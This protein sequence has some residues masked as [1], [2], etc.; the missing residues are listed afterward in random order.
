[1]VFAFVSSW[2]TDKQTHQ[3]GANKDHFGAKLEVGEIEQ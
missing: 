1:M 2:C 3:H